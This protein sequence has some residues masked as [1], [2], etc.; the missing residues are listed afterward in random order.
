MTLPPNCAPLKENESAPHF[1]ADERNLL[2]PSV[3]ASHTFH[4]LHVHIYENYD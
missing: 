2:C 1:F 4:P 3:E